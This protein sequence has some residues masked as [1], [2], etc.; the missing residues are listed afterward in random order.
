MEEKSIGN[1][2]QP[3]KG[4]FV[5]LGN[6]LFTPVPAGHDQGHPRLLHQQVMQGTIGKHD[7]Q[8]FLSRG[9]GLGD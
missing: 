8:V 9:H 4:F 2:F 6:G 5:I 3:D 1:A 7:P